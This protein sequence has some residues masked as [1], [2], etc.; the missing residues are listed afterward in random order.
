[1]ASEI[2]TPVE[3]L[4]AARELIS[5]PARWTKGADARDD[6]GEDVSYHSEAA[7]CWCGIGAL[8]HVTMHTGLGQEQA[9]QFLLQ[10]SGERLFS[11]FNDASEH[12]DV[13]GAFDRAIILAQHH[14]LAKT[15]TAP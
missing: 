11:T 6:S 3:A 8:Y 2:K 1:M 10:A 14:A 5:D 15:G 9:R 7:T 12:S 13:L 4:R